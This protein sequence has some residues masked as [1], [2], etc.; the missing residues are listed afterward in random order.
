MN[1]VV[2]NLS[3]VEVMFVSITTAMFLSYCLYMIV[4]MLKDLKQ[5]KQN[6]LKPTENKTTK[7]PPT[8]EETE[9]Y[10]KSLKEAGWIQYGNSSIWSKPSKGES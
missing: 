9:A 5:E 2:I 1:E 6:Y 10:K 7:R 3:V 4:S 8:I